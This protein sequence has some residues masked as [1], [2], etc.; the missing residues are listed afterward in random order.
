MLKKSRHVNAI[1]TSEILHSTSNNGNKERLTIDWFAKVVTEFRTELS[2][3][4]EAQ[5]NVTRRLQQRNQCAEEMVELRDDFD[6]LKLEWNAVHLRQNNLDQAIKDLQTEA[7]QRDDDFR[8]S[9]L[10]VSIFMQ[11]TILFSTLL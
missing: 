9:Q 4:Q 2:E 1:N 7:I 11:F 3:L 5:S 8:R 10:Q 6:K